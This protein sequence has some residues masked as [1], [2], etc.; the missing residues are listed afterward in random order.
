MKKAKTNTQKQ[1]DFRAKKEAEGYVQIHVWVKNETLQK[2]TSF[3]D[4]NGLTKG[5]AL[6]K[7][8]YL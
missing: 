8:A 6:D 2:I 7:L 5:Q 3:A 1:A 4:S